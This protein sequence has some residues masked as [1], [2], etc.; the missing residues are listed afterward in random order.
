MTITTLTM[1]K[2]QKSK[3]KQ[4]ISRNKKCSSNVAYYQTMCQKQCNLAAECVASILATRSKPV[5]EKMTDWC[6]SNALSHNTWKRNFGARAK[7]QKV[8]SR[9]CMCS[10]ELKQ[11]S[12]RDCTALRSNEQHMQNMHVLKVMISCSVAS[13]VCLPW[14]WCFQQLQYSWMIV[15]NLFKW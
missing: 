8:T 11:V 13:T 5:M 3:K 2:Q 9:C 15:L 14:K 6:G 12:T 1:W 4:H 10:A 7:A